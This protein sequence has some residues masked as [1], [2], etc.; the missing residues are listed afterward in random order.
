MRTDD[1]TGLLPERAT[2]QHMES[3]RIEPSTESLQ[4]T[5][6]KM[7]VEDTL[8]RV[9]RLDMATLAHIHDRYYPDVYRFIRYRLNDEHISEDIASE[10]FMR[11]L[12]ALHQQ[13][14]PTKD[15]R[16]WLIG[17]ASHLVNDHLRVQYSRKTE[18]IENED[19]FVDTNNPEASLDTL[20]QNQQLRHAIT[21]LTPEQ[22]DVLALRFVEEYSLEQTA[23]HLKKTV[24]AVK[25]LQFRAIESLKRFL[26]TPVQ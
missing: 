11:L 6:W 20:M 7:G 21:R 22:Q 5:G 25:A 10:V 1:F 12:D 15:L 16:S 26:E 8:T 13:G 3:G 4:L 14:G 18:P 24:N 23:T 9:R 19:S 2:L 17:T